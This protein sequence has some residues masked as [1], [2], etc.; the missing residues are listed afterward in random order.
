MFRRYQL[1]PKDFSFQGPASQGRAS[2]MLTGKS[3]PVVTAKPRA[4]SDGM[5][6][7]DAL[8]RPP[9]DQRRDDVG[10]IVFQTFHLNGL[11]D[12]LYTA[13]SPHMPG[14][15]DSPTTRR[16]PGNCRVLRDEE[17]DFEVEKADG[18]YGDQAAQRGAG[19]DSEGMK[20]VVEAWWMPATALFAESR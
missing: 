3:S 17:D 7:A 4:T 1:L 12:R 9:S 19:G 10:R 2:A 16:L 13:S 11:P 18:V 14:N 8:V 15:S 5:H 20:E 6:A